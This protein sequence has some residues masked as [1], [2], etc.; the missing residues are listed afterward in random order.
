[1][2]DGIPFGV[3]ALSFP[4]GMDPDQLAAVLRALQGGQGAPQSAPDS[5]LVAALAGAASML[6][7]QMPDPQMPA[8]QQGAPV[9]ST[10]QIPSM[11][12]ARPPAMPDLAQA[13][14]PAS[15]T[16]GAVPRPPAAATQ[17]EDEEPAAKPAGLTNPPLP[18]TR[19]SEFSA[20]GGMSPVS[21][22]DPLTGQPVS[23]SPKPVAAAA[24]AQASGGFDIGGAL[25][26]MNQSGLADQLIAMGAGILQGGNFGEGLGRGLQN[27]LSVSQASAK[28]DAERAKL[29]REQATLAGNVAIYKRYFPNA[30]DQEA[31]AGSANSTIMTDLLKRGLPP[32]ETYRQETDDKGNQWQVNSANGQRSLLKSADEDKTVTPLA[33]DE[34]Q[35]LGLPAGV[36]QKDAN[37]KIATVATVPESKAVTLIPEAER[38]QLGLPPGSYQR[39]VYGKISPIGQSGVTVNLPPA[40][41]AE[42]AKI[43]EARGNVVADQITAGK[44]AQD[45][46]RTLDQMSGAL[47]AAG[48]NITTGPLGEPVLR[49]KQALGGILGRELPGTSATE[50][51][52]NMG[53]ILAGEAARAITNRPAQIEFTTMLNSKPGLMNSVEGN[54]AMMDVMRQRA[55]QDSDLANIAAR[56]NSTDEFLHKKDEYEAAHPMINPFTGQAFGANG[57]SPGAEGGPQSSSAPIVQVRSAAERDGLPTGARYIAPDGKLRVKQ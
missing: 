30:T 35:R 38:A 37:G 26:R 36:Y 14:A 56:S 15:Q 13:D 48:G 39:D 47:A 11:L 21:S 17:G 51:F 34:R 9:P 33:D 19:P 41:K 3:S 1:M 55:V 50:M 27:A 10:A 54:R 29:A 24:P 12:G 31:L 18:P 25:R 45:R 5:P 46:I 52:N 28:T 4:G 16:T 57:T 8:P 22:F 40:E 32:T 20:L 44:S 53:P 2:S 49:A 6:G 23:G 43:G 42:Q 7:G